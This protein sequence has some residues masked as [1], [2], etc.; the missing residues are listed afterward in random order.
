MIGLL[1]PVVA[2]GLRWVFEEL[3]PSKRN[4]KIRIVDLETQIKNLTC[5][6][7][8]LMNSH[9]QIMRD[10]LEQLKDKKSYAISSEAIAVIKAT[11]GSLD[12]NE[13]KFNQQYSIK[14]MTTSEHKISIFDGVEDEILLARLKRPSEME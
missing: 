8:S 9:K 7:Q 14:K 12:T 4:M 1:G 6:N 5:G 2:E 10:I 13:T 11:D 3:S